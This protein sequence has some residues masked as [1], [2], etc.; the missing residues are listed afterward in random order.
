M[1]E[2]ELVIDEH[3][4]EIANLKEHLRVACSELGMARYQDKVNKETIANLQR[5]ISYLNSHIKSAPHLA[6]KEGTVRLPL[7]SIK[8]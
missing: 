8:L 5:E 2:Y 7:G 1:I 4:K 6:N 3:K